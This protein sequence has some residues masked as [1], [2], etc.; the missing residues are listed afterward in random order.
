MKNK[1]PL[2]TWGWIL[3]ITVFTLGCLKERTETPTKGY[4]Q[5]VASEAIQPMLKEQESR[6]EE[7]YVN[8]KIDIQYTTAREAVTRIFNDTIKMI[9]TS[10]PLNKEEREVAKRTNLQL[11]EYKIAVD[12]IAIIVNQQNRVSQLRTTQ[13]DSIYRGL[14]TNWGDLGSD[15]S[16]IEI[17][18]PDRNTG[19]FEVIGLKILAGRTFTQPVKVVSTSSE[20]IEFVS[21]RSG[22]I[23]M[24][25]I[26]WLRSKNENIKILELSDPNAPD[27]LDISGQY[28]T[29]HQAHVYRGYYPLTSEIYIYSKADMYSVAAGF[30]TFIAS[31]P[32]QKIVLDNGLVPATMP[33]RL[34]ELTNRSLPQ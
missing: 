31:V 19:T 14:I 33:V 15:K 23:G 29:P 21:N 5:V 2:M 32:G 16:E 10:R 30:I 8:A 12:G 3:L 7:L 25:S 13:L 22:G 26:D 11:A 34:V 17:C 6:F 1:Y 27:S 9:V 18:L 20:M 28:F 4:L 24:V